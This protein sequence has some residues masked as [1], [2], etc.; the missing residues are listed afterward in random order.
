MPQEQSFPDA[1]AVVEAI[2]HL[3]P[4]AMRLLSRSEAGLLREELR[5]DIARLQTLAEG[6]D[7]NEKA[8]SEDVLETLKEVRQRIEQTLH[9]FLRLGDESG[10][11]APPEQGVLNE[12]LRQISL[13]LERLIV[14][15]EAWFA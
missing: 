12:E 3:K 13:R 2:R 10:Q 6:D 1:S 11:P 8:V 15:A 7:S 14:A 4:E 5:S 9:D